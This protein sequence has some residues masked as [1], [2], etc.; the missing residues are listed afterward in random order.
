MGLS[1]YE[2]GPFSNSLTSYSQYEWFVPVFSISL[3]QKLHSLFS[4]LSFTLS[5]VVARNQTILK[6]NYTSNSYG[7]INDMNIPIYSRHDNLTRGGDWGRCLIFLTPNFIENK[8]IW[9]KQTINVMTCG[10]QWFFLLTLKTISIFFHVKNSNLI[11]GFCEKK[12]LST[13]SIH[14]QPPIP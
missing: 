6:K 2:L 12:N 11:F 4:E 3:I 1:L 7:N 9:N 5:M 8:Q 10:L 13:G 14:S